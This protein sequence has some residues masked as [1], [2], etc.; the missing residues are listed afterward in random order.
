MSKSTSIDRLY[1][2]LDCNFG[3]HGVQEPITHN[4]GLSYDSRAWRKYAIECYFKKKPSFIQEALATWIKVT[5]AA[6]GEGK[7]PR[8]EVFKKTT[9]LQKQYTSINRQDNSISDDEQED[10]NQDPCC[11]KAN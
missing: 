9:K 11:H 1:P 6:M 3:M 10:Q 7:D 5:H 2:M 8:S 4:T